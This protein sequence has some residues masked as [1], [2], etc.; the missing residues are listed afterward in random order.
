MYVIILACI[1]S[2]TL[3]AKTR[4]AHI[5]TP[6]RQ[7]CNCGGGVLATLISGCYSLN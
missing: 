4:A 2:Y 1:T 5:L 3:R 7:M 6:L